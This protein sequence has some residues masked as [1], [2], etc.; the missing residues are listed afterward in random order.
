MESQQMIMGNMQ[1]SKLKVESMTSKI[2]VKCEI[3]TFLII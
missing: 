2:D 3:K 1:I